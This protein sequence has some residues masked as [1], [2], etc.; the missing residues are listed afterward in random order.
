MSGQIDEAEVARITQG[1]TEAQRAALSCPPCWGLPEGHNQWFDLSYHRSEDDE[2]PI[3]H[4]EDMDAIMRSGLVVADDPDETAGAHLTDDER[5]VGAYWRINITPLG[6]AV[7]K[8]L[9]AN[10][11][12]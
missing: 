8:H 9:E 5:D 4:G 1:L 11:A 7:R 6:L 12:G 2:E 3:C 10:N